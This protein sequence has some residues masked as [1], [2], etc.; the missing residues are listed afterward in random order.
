MY[1]LPSTAICIFNSN[2]IQNQTVV[3]HP[4]TS[5]FF[6]IGAGWFGI[7]KSFSQFVLSTLPCLQE[8]GNIGYHSARVN[9]PTTSS[10]NRNEQ[11][12]SD[13][14]DKYDKRSKEMN[15]KNDHLKPVVPII[16]IDMPD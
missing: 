10:S 4:F 5:L 8:Y 11:A 14:H 9:Q 13:D 12:T 1:V 16:S 7:R 6:F 3:I 2:I 15:K